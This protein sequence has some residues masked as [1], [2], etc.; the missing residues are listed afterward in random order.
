MALGVSAYSI[1][2]KHNV[3]ACIQVILGARKD[4]F[5]FNQFGQKGL[6]ST[7]KFLVRISFI[8]PDIYDSPGIWRSNGAPG[9]PSTAQSA[10]WKKTTWLR[11]DS[12]SEA[13]CTKSFTE[14]GEYFLK[15]ITKNR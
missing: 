15:R 14:I 10:E 7:V 5:I 4:H 1:R 6:E 13:M 2:R 3:L 9:K 11:I 12:E 8:R